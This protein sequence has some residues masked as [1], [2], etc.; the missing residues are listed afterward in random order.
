MSVREKASRLFDRFK[1][2]TPHEGRTQPDTCEDLLDQIIIGDEVEVRS[3]TNS[4]DQQTRQTE[5]N[6]WLQMEI[7]EILQTQLGEMFSLPRGWK[8]RLDDDRLTLDTQDPHYL[9]TGTTNQELKRDLE[10]LL[11]AAQTENLLKN[12]IG[13]RVQQ[14]L[15][16]HKTVILIALSSA[17]DT[18]T[19]NHP[20][21]TV[22][23]RYQDLKRQLPPETAPSDTRPQT[24]SQENPQA[25]SISLIVDGE[26]INI[27]AQIAITYQDILASRLQYIV[28]IREPV[29]DLVQTQFLTA[30]LN[31]LR[32]DI[33][34]MKKEGKNNRRIYLELAVR[35][36]PDIYQQ[37]PE[38][39]R[40][41]A[42]EYFQALS[43]LKQNGEI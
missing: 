9:G 13:V 5:R 8:I 26:Q 27:P 4:G 34:R 36:H 16:T 17:L 43:A 35:Y 42:N 41:L 6:P 7:Q 24:R 33:A 31:D 10:R 30:V 19:T 3:S 18:I 2:E 1:H 14:L 11:H 20:E 37:A 22:D 40:H 39:V 32:E 15:N 23:Q 29:S 25:T 28:E 21:T 38:E 12:E